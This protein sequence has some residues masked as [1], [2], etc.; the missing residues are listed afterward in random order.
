[1]VTDEG[2]FVVGMLGM[3]SENDTERDR[4][5]IQAGQVD[6]A[7]AAS[8]GERGDDVV[9][10]AQRNGVVSSHRRLDV[11]HINVNPRCFQ[12]PVLNEQDD[13]K[14]CKTAYRTPFP[15]ISNPSPAVFFYDK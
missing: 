1:L 2:V 15:W 4:N 8:S 9:A 14:Q 11:F 6:G 3:E 5:K 7:I 13:E 12:S 10:V